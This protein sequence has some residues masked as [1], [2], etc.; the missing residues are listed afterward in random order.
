[1]NILNSI[2]ITRVEMSPA[3]ETSYTAE[4]PSKKAICTMA[5]LKIIELCLIICCV[6]LI[7]EPATHSQLRAF[8]TPRV[9]AI[10]YLTFGCFLIYTAIY[11]IMVLVGEIL[12]WRHNALW[13]FVAVTL[14]V[15]SSGLLFRNWSQMKEYNY[16]HPNMQRLD[17][18]LAT[19][20][21][22]LVTALILIFDLCVTVRFG[23][24]GDLD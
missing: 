5:F 10:C 16:W 22:S 19:A 23:I 20:S 1:M 4:G 15:I 6:G 14:F 13:M 21:V 8:V 17:L 24:Q 7:D 2:E 12:N 11:L 3:E 18:V 9:C